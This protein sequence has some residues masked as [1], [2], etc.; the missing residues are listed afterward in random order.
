M[1]ELSGLI[2]KGSQTIIYKLAK[3]KLPETILCSHIPC[4]LKKFPLHLSEYEIR[5]DWWDWWYNIV[6]LGIY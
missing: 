4:K 6:I 2:L 1:Y 3:P 5:W